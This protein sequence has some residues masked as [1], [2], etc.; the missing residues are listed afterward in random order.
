M[1]Y[2]IHNAIGKAALAPAMSARGGLFLLRR[3]STAQEN[4]FFSGHHNEGGN[5][6]L[7]TKEYEDIEK[8]V[9]QGERLSR[10][11]GIRLFHCHDLAWLGAL[12]DHVRQEK[13]GDIVY[14]NV[15]CHVNLTNICTSHCEFCAFGRDA[16]DK[17]AYAMTKEQAI[18]LVRE[19]LKDPD[20]GGLHV[21]SGLHPTWSFEQYLGILQALHEEFPQLYLKGFTGVEI[22]HFAKISGLSVREVLEKLKAA[23]LKAIAG[24]GAEILSDRVRQELCPNKAT[25]EEW[26]N[27]ARTAHQLGIPTYASMLYGHIETLEERVD[28][29][30][31]LRNL[32]DETHGFQTF[33]CFPFLPKH[34][35][36]GQRI[37]QTSMW[38]DLRT[39]AIARLMLD[40]FRNIKAYW[41]MLTVP[42]AQVALGFGAND[43]D[44]TIH[45]ENIMH[46]AGAESPRGLSEDTIIRIIKEAGR[47]PALC[48]C[49]FNIIRTID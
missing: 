2:N 27:V 12:A 20:M 10:E 46:D 44:G 18:G 1:W 49:N 6:L 11:D 41:V 35:K 29:L 38:D 43:I 30:L 31:K 23:G 36:L 48:D 7:A 45:K 19:A 14:Y 34:T 28:H 15:N 39:M 17:G 4:E 5:I 47:V 25:A 21:V 32:Q 13:C 26:L 9:L 33:I 37:K 16:G 42:V 3:R 24:G 8:K 22:T 40:N